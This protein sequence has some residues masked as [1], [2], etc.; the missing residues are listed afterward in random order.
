M[1]VCACAC[2]RACVWMSSW[3]CLSVCLRLHRWTSKPPPTPVVDAFA[4]HTKSEP[5]NPKPETQTSKL[6]NTTPETRQPKKKVRKA[7]EVEE[8]L[9]KTISLKEVLTDPALVALDE[10]VPYQP[11]T[12]SPKPWR[13]RNANSQG[14]CALFR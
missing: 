12:P 8:P 11:E 10:K 6:L 3:P 5:R 13:C 14:L 2:V 4:L 7:R 1:C 9:V